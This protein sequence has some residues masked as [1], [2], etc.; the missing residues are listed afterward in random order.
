MVKKARTISVGLRF[1]SSTFYVCT[2]F[3]YG[4][5]IANFAV[6][7]HKKEAFWF[8]GFLIAL[9]RC[10]GPKVSDFYLKNYKKNQNRKLGKH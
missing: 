5:S 9:H 6:F 1:V 2:L 3:L 8:A 10:R 4:N 7:G